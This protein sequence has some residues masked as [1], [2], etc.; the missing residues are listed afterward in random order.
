VRAVAVPGAAEI[1]WSVNSE[2]DLA[3][4]NVYRDGAPVVKLNR[5]LLQIPVFRDNGTTAG[6]RH[7]YRVTA[8]DRNGNESAPSEQVTVTAE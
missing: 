6:A 2:S 4:Y 8:V 1:V 7:S 5:E 3:G